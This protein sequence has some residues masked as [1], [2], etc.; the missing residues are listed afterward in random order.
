MDLEIL[1]VVIHTP[2]KRNDA[3]ELS[4][5]LEILCVSQNTVIRIVILDQI[6]HLI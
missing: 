5:E 2:E 6:I 3:I 4:Q 1:N